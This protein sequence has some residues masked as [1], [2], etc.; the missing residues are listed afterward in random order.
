MPR[1]RDC[2]HFEDFDPSRLMG[3]CYFGW[4]RSRAVPVEE[5]ALPPPPCLRAEFY[6]DVRSEDKVCWWQANSPSF[7]PIENPPQICATCGNYIITDRD[8]P[9]Q[10]TFCV[11]HENPARHTHLWKPDDFCSKWVPRQEPKP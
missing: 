5:P 2:Q 8:T 3:K 7:K 11:G 4:I 10:Q 1:C 9:S 6:V